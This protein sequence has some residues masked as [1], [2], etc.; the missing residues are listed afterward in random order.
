MQNPSSPSISRE[1][2]RFAVPMLIAQ[3]ALMANAVIDTVMAGR[4]TA[5][6]LAAVGIGASVQVTV[7]VSLIAVLLA[8]PPMVAHLYGA[9]RRGEVGRELHQAVWIAIVIAAV[10]M[11]VLLH[12]DFIITHLHVTHEVEVKL[13]AY[14]TASAMSVPAMVAFRL[15]VGLSTG[16]GRP[17]PVMVFNLIALGMKVPLNAVF[18]FGLLGVPAMGGPG[19]AVATAIDQWTIAI[20]AWTWCL[21]NSHYREFNLGRPFARPSWP[22]IR[23][24]LKLGVPIG[25]SFVADVTAFTLMALFIARLGPVVAGAH[26]IAANLSATAFMLP[27]SLG[28]ATVALAGRALG[29]G[30]P[31]RARRISWRGVRLAMTA[32]LAISAAYL[33]GAPWIAA[34]YTD[35]HAVQAAA[36]PLIRLAGV[37]HLADALQAV[38]V[39]ALRGYKKSTVPMLVYGVLL[40]G[41]GLGGGVVLGLTPTFGHPLGASGFW[42]AETFALFAVAISMAL[43]LNRV[44]RAMAA[45]AW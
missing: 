22:L 5:V 15:F 3:L 10:A 32:A 27:L 8:L 26:Q 36:I 45:Q 19:A 41:P 24:F 35:D 31:L 28:T 29:A 7:V 6:D 12:P 13:R 1:L 18:M 21:H 42:I 30:D 40:W 2:I 14:L 23:E 4:I 38:T 25:L 11:A 20:L 44:S 37:Y 9:D 17:R 39:N 43:Y 16:L 34:A 33:F